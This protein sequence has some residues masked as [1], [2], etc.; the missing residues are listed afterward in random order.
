LLALGALLVGREIPSSEGIT[1]AARMKRSDRALVSGLRR[2]NRHGFMHE[3]QP[4]LST[5]TSPETPFDGTMS[6]APELTVDVPQRRR[7]RPST[8]A[9]GH[10][11][12]AFRSRASSAARRRNL[13]AS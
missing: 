7:P 5:K 6:A 13:Q 11:A 8:G 12:C 3:R 9:T 4:D 10:P 2:A 1:N